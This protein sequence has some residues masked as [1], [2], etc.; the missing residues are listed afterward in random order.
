LSQ[1]DD[2]SAAWQLPHVPLVRACVRAT[3]LTHTCN[4]AQGSA[5]CSN[6]AFRMQHNPRTALGRPHA[7]T[8][9]PSNDAASSMLL[10]ACIDA[11]RT[12]QHAPCST[13]HQCFLP[14]T[15]RTYRCALTCE[16]FAT[17]RSKIPIRVAANNEKKGTNSAKRWTN[18]ATKG[19]RSASK[20]AGHTDCALSRPPCRHALNSTTRWAAEQPPI[21]IGTS[22]SVARV[23][24]AAHRVANYMYV[25]T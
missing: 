22:V 15:L 21:L 20:L 8:M 25:H 24:E 17:G 23:N 19:Y 7:A 6:A 2:L 12:V 4:D 16:A 10:G 14:V 18:N 9:Q 1:G 5:P 11:S 3:V 13:P